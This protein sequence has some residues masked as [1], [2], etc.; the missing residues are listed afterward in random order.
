[1]HEVELFKLVYIFADI[2]GESSW[3]AWSLCSKN[4]GAWCD[5]ALLSWD[6]RHTYVCPCVNTPV[7]AVC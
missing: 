6:V 3:V 7:D 1:V 5:C 2:V 4:G